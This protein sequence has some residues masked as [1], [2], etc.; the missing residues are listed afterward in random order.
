MSER[1][2]LPGLRRGVVTVPSSKSI[3]HRALIAAALSEAEPPL[4]RGESKDTQ[5]TRNCLRAMM[6]GET[7]WPC[8]ESGTTLRLL[9]PIAGV[10][11]WRGRFVCEGRLGE[12]PRL[13]FA[14]QSRYVVPGN[15]SSQFVSGLL[16][17]LP[18][19]DRDSEIVVEGKLQSEAYV[20]LTEDTLLEAGIAFEKRGGSWFVKGGQT[21]RFPGGR[22][23]EGDWSQAAFFL[24]MGVGVRGVD[25]ASHQG[26]RAVVD[27]LREIDA[28]P[29]GC[30]KTLDLSQTPDLYPVLAAYAAS[31]GSGVTF[32]GTERLRFK[33]SDRL[34]S[35]AAMID[36][37]KTGAVVKTCNDHRI[38]MSAAVMACRARSP[39][40]VDDADCVAKSYPGFWTDFDSLERIP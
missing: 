11:G 20:R 38:A 4:I 19:A 16:M 6:R 31:V 34:A 27:L 40:M 3:A 24:A 26:D 36:A 28:C 18:L 37:V 22:E 1:T 14:R 29:T 13:P 35:T 17:A 5:A 8:G 10:M 21:Y 30:G 2:I 39:V 32:S 23:V 12:R 25:A 9:E 7:E 33:E 15:V